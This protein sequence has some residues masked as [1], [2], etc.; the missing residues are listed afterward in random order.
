MTDVLGTSAFTEW[1]S[2]RADREEALRAPHGWLAPVALY[3]LG[4]RPERLDGVLGDWWIDHDVV[5]VR[6]REGESLTVDGAEI[7]GEAALWQ[8]GDA[9]PFVAHD[10]FQYELLVRDGHFGL[11]VR[12]PEAPTRTHF[13]G[14]PT[15][16]YD[17]AWVV[18]AS[19][20]RAP[21][22][23][24][25]VVGTTIPW[26]RQV[27]SLLGRARFTRDG[28]D[29][30]VLL[31]GSGS[32]ATLLFRDK[33]SGVTTYGASRTVHVDLADGDDEALL[34]FNRSVNLPCALTDFCTCPVPPPENII[35]IAIEAG[36]KKPLKA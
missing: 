16:D 3:W 4:E 23:D 30:E 5:N 24:Q 11:R 29:V 14:I 25:I 10:R 34:D 22:S 27:H 28:V 33:T 19:F 15:Y 12:D 13:S 7:R 18:S 20:E 6:L 17:P 35:P 1:E 21:A 26:Q 32:G 2:W 9:V 31:T 36:E 8:V